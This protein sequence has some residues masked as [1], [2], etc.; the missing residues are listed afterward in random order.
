MPISFRQAD[1]APLA[2]R[3]TVLLGLFGFAFFAYVQ[4]T[5]IAVAAERMMPELGL[6]QI[7]LGWL[8]TAFLV[9]YSALQVPAGWLGERIGA[10]LTLVIASSLALLAT[11][12]TVAAPAAFTGTGLVIAL[13]AARFA[14][15]VAQAPVFP[16]ASGVIEL[17]F[18]RVRW[19]LAQG[20]FNSGLNLGAAATP[21][22]IAALMLIAGWRTALLASSAPL[23]ALTLYWYFRAHDDPAGDRRVSH[24]ELAELERE[25]RP[26]KAAPSVGRVL[27]LLCNRDLGALTASYLF[28]NYAFYLLTFWCFLYFSQERHFSSMDSGWLAA[29][30]FCAAGVGAALGGWW[31]QGLCRRLGERWGF[32]CIPL[33]ALPLAALTLYLAVNASSAL[34]ADAAL[35][36]AFAAIEI[37]EGPYWAAA[38]RIA[39]ADSM[40]ATGLLNTGG[41]LGGI[42]ATPVIAALS[43]EHGW[44]AAFLTGSGCALAAA[45]LWLRVDPTRQD[46][47]ARQ[48]G[49]TDGVIAC[50]P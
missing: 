33:I 21:P 28:M 29:A 3:W 49:A 32:R 24:A 38:M 17:W 14:L 10:R 46:A 35:C 6:T 47:A 13:V 41:N 45:L 27:S 48:Q 26:P 2:V 40:V 8:L 9:S 16:V 31:N 19:S 23:L 37:T 4:R 30:P 12:A 34:S 25:V 42:I 50:P 22:L 15:G 11:L 7:E 20:L 43:A 5:G 1:R 44:S 18:P 39:S 36:V